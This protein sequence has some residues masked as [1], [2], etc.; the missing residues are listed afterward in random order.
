VQLAVTRAINVPVSDGVVTQIRLLLTPEA[1]VN[2]VAANAQ[3]LDE[4]NA[5]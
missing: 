5:P 4:W 3:V 2:G 1:Q